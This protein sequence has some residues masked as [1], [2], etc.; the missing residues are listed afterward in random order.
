VV[1]RGDAEIGLQ[2]VS[3]L[4]HV[5]GITYVGPIPA[6]LDR[7]SSYAAA[8]TAQAKEPEAAKELIKLLSSPRAESIILKTGLT[9][10]ARSSKQ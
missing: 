4:I 8:I 2:D 5:P 6:E 1:A 3:E 9:P 10:P 7:H